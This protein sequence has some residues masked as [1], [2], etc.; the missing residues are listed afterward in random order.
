[1]K[2]IRIAAT[3]LSLVAVSVLVAGSRSNAGA[4]AVVI[5]SLE[6]PAGPG[7]AESN[8]TV[9]PDGRVFLSW[10]E[11]APDSAM[12]MRFASFDGTKWSA[13]QTIRSGRE[14]FVNWADF[15][16]LAV[17]ANGRMAAHWLQRFGATSY[18]YDVRIAQSSDGGKTWG[19]AVQPH[20]DRSATE[21]GF[22]TMWPEGEG[23]GAVWLDGR[24]ADKAGKN[25]VQEMMLFA[26]TLGASQAAPKETL[27]DGRTC[28]C[29]Q[30]TAAMTANGPLI[31]YRDRTTNE[32]R[33]IYVTR[34]VRGAWTEPKA[35]YA[36][37]WE[38][39][40][41]PVNGPSVDAAGQRVA[42]AWY[43]G[44]KDTPRVKLAFSSDAGA[45]FSAPIT[46]DE[47]NP[48]GRVAAVLLADGSALVS[49]I[50]RTGGDTASVRVRRVRE[51]EGVSPA[52]TV[53]ASSA[54]RASGFPRMV[55]AGDQVYF[56]WT[57]P[58]RPSTVRLARAN[59]QDIR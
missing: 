4:S 48:A 17:R 8:L 55:R 35:L 49:W 43:T 29:C 9:G 41:C 24:K 54:A 25:P 12:A 26:T 53:A 56:A 7:A 21:K 28:D 5:Q 45:T 32:I 6:S 31:A 50:E 47:G 52:T 27:L 11:P 2:P 38:I 39:N 15:P 10:L 57:V 44:A 42:L 1:M 23:F 51:K 16:S 3:A 22:V 20:A 34:R 46:I 13:P 36:D 59:A 19:T 58:G 37:G 14:F 18:A 30:T 33:D 40:A